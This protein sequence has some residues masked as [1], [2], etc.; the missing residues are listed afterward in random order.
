MLIWVYL[1]CYF[2]KKSRDTENLYR[3]EI[4]SKKWLSASNRLDNADF[5]PP[6]NGN[7]RGK[8]KASRPAGFRGLATGN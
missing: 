7:R 4:I 3:F 2:T 5:M 6:S 1:C 8:K